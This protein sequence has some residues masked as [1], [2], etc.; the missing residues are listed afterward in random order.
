M[1][2]DW[3]LHGIAGRVVAGRMVAAAALLALGYSGMPGAADSARAQDNLAY[4][5]TSLFG[6][7][8]VGGGAGE[9]A[10]GD[11]T[12]ELDLAKGRMCY[13]LEVDGLDIFS[14]AHIH[15]GAKGE[16]GPPAIE[17]QLSGPKGDD[18]CVNADPALLKDIVKRKDRYYVSVHTVSFPDGAVRGQ[19][20]Q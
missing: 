20:D 12:A 10:S 18:I 3:K 7:Y 6:E 13:L 5:G 9:D 1:P 4:L 14:S 16:N 19:L 17:L 11:F 8:V 15:E 2:W